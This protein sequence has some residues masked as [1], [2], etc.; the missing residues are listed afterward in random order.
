MKYVLP[1][2]LTL[3]GSTMA[4][5]QG[6]CPPPNCTLTCAAAAAVAFEMTSHSSPVFRQLSDGT[7][8]RKIDP[9]TAAVGPK[10]NYSV[11]IGTLPP[12]SFSVSTTRQFATLENGPSA[13]GKCFNIRA[14]GFEDP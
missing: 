14:S 9:P 12:I 11:T 13:P 1:L 2:T 6:V 4:F 10:V 3:V 7:E 8:V 5:A